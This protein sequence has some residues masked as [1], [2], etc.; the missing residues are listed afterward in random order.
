[1]SSSLY[2]KIASAENKIPTKKKKLTSSSSR[3][4]K[5][6]SKA[7]YIAKSVQIIGGNKVIVEDPYLL[8]ESPS[9]NKAIARELY[10]DK[11]VNVVTTGTNSPNKVKPGQMNLFNPSG[12]DKNLKPSDIPSEYRISK[13]A[14]PQTAE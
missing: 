3:P 4:S 13:S 1:M 12:Y 6:Q 7:E 10:I 2:E 5:P 9:I 11:T 8:I 14:K